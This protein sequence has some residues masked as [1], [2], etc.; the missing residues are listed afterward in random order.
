MEIKSFFIGEWPDTS[1]MNF[2]CTYDEA[3]AT[4]NTTEA[5]M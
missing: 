1:N 3:T 4:A 5:N 2:F